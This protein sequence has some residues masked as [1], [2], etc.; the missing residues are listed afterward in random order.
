M[1]VGM[2]AIVLVGAVLIVAGNLLPANETANDPEG[3]PRAT[4]RATSRPTVRPTPNLPVELSLEPALMPSPVPT[5]FQPFYG[6]IRAEVDLPI[7]SDNSEFGNPFGVLPAGAVAFAHEQEQDQPPGDGGWLYI[8]EPAPSGWVATRDEA[9]GNDLVTRFGQG[10]FPV[11]GS[12]WYL[13]GGSEGYLGIGQPAGTSANYPPVGIFTSTDGLAWQ[14][15]PDAPVPGCCWGTPAWGPAGWL[16]VGSPP[17]DRGDSST[18]VW[19]SPDGL[20]WNAPGVISGGTRDSGYPMLFEG[21]DIGYLLMTSYGGTD[22]ALWFSVDGATWLRSDLG[23]PVGSQISLAALPNGFYAWADAS[24]TG[25][26]GFGAYSAD[27]RTWVPTSG[28]PDVASADIVVV[29]DVVVATETDPS[30]GTLRAWRGTI[31][32]DTLSW[33]I[34]PGGTAPFTGA[35][36]S[37][38]ASDGQQ[39]VAVGWDLSTEAPLA[40]STD[41]GAWRHEVLPSEFEGIATLAAGG[42]DGVVVIGHHWTSRGDNPVAWLRS[43]SGTW[44]SAT[45]SLVAEAPDI[46]PADCLGP[47]TEAVEF[48]SIDR[49]AAVACHGAKPLTFRAWSSRC[50]GCYG[51]YG[52]GYEPA[53]LAAPGQNQLFL[54]PIQSS[55]YWITALLHPD[56][57]P[58]PKDEQLDTWLEIT[59]HFDDPDAATCHWTPT[60]QEIGYYSGQRWV[61]EGCRQQFVVTAVTVVDGP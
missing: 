59:G 20:H 41:G 29:R 47:P 23:Q 18:W 8:D 56:V 6:W 7:L 51:G 42:P 40:W 5:D 34:M 33:S 26:P 9:T 54:S 16:V 11:P 35:V 15:A 57:G 48:V 58:S 10:A 39:A 46:L 37:T 36:V 14:T 61:M 2:A 38:M 55:G 27:G 12:I 1:L 21:S 45:T 44:S 22:G 4:A 49:A 24:Q 17:D 19:N 32:G 50:D 60:P 53:W 28:G 43:P 52:E 31:A 25:G 30:T 13:E 3:S